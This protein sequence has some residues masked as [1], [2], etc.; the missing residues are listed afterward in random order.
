MRRDRSLRRAAGVEGVGTAGWTH[1]PRVARP[2]P[3][4]DPSEALGSWVTSQSRCD[5]AP[6]SILAPQPL[7]QEHTVS[8][9]SWTLQRRCLAALGIV[10]GILA[11]PPEAFG[12]G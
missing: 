11:A 8:R 12:Q 5:H 10:A 3:R 9:G 7:Q 6:T 1:D 2:G 4:H